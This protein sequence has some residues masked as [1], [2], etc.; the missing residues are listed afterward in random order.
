MGTQVL[1]LYP[2]TTSF[3][4]ATVKSAPLP[5]TGNG[6]GVRGGNGRADPGAVKRKYRLN[7]VDDGEKIHE[8]HKDS[9]ILVSPSECNGANE[10]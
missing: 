6:L 3:Y 2:D 4:Q 5:G 1:G 10:V 7:F 8:I 9:V